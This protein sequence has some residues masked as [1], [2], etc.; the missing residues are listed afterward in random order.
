MTRFIGYAVD[1]Y[2]TDLNAP[3]STG[4]TKEEAR[5]RA[6]TRVL[7][8]GSSVNKKTLQEQRGRYVPVQYFTPQGMENNIWLHEH[9][10][11]LIEALRHAPADLCRQV[12]EV[13][14]YDPGRP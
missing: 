6:I 7:S 10:H 14:G 4:Q 11:K 12:A 2:D 3:V 1:G 5:D 13:L 9:R 8:M